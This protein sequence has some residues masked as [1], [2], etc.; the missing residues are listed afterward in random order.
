[1]KKLLNQDII[2]NI[3]SQL[4]NGMLVLHKDMKMAHRDLK[5][6]NILFANGKWKLGD[7][8]GAKVVEAT[9]LATNN[10]SLVGTLIYLSPE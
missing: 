8:G 10:H 2:K 7:L 6:R 4:S 1:M 5:P 9:K 3:L